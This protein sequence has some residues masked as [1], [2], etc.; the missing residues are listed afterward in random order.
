MRAEVAVRSLTRDIRFVVVDCETTTSDS[1]QHVVSLAVVPYKY[2]QK[3]TTGERYWLVNPQIAIETVSVHGIEDADVAGADTFDLIEPELT[4]KLAG[5]GLPGRTVFVAHYAA[6]DLRA[7]KLE[8]QRLNTPMPTL[9]VLDTYALARHLAVPSEG[10]S[11]RKLLAYWDRRP[12]QHH[13]AL[14]DA[15]DTVYVLARLL[16]LAAKRGHLDLDALIDEVTPGKA[17]TDDWDAGEPTRATG[18][19]SKTRFVHIDRPQAH[20]AS[21]N[22]LSGKPTA[23]ALPAW[24]DAL[25]ECVTLRC[26]RLID[27]CASLSTHH[28]DVV[29]ALRADL[30]AH[31]AAGR[32]VDANTV[33]FAISVLYRPSVIT[34]KHASKSP[35]ATTISDFDHFHDLLTT[36][37]RCDLTQTT[38]VDACPGCRARVTCGRDALIREIAAASLYRRYRETGLKNWVGTGGKL[39]KNAADRPALAAGQGDAI[40]AVLER[41]AYGSSTSVAE[42]LRDLDLTTPAAA[43]VLARAALADGSL[44]KAVSIARNAF[45][46]RDGDTRTDWNELADYVTSLEARQARILRATPPPRPYRRGH[47]APARKSNRRFTIA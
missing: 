39:A 1:G 7:I 16:E 26:P 45:D 14:H 9:P 34:G 21:H 2:G 37:P 41:A 44:D 18:D 47:T 42:T 8:Y 12:S 30:D 46:H 35:L 24:L 29:D 17:T 10:Y 28:A 31:V 23:A 38:R 43:I 22:T 40:I 13:H 11:L 19:G 36:H 25:R 32:A 6:S 5:V 4:S 20:F 27:R 3:T 33:L 15:N